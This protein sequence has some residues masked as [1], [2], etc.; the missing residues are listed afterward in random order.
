[1]SD[2]FDV[3]EDDPIFGPSSPAAPEST[4]VIDSPRQADPPGVLVFDVE[5]GPLSNDELDALMPAYDEAALGQSPGEF[6]PASVKYGN[7]KDEA[8]KAEKLAAAKAAHEQAVSTWRA[9]KNREEFEAKLRFREMAALSPVTGKVLAIEYVINGEHV[10][11]GEHVDEATLIDGWLDAVCEAHLTGNKIVGFNILGFDIPFLIRR[12]WKL[13][14]HV[15]TFLNPAQPWKCGVFIDLLDVWKCGSRF[16][17]PKHVDDKLA[18]V[19][20]FFGL[21]GKLDGLNGGDFHRLWN[22]SPEEREKALAYLTRDVEITY[23]VAKAMG[24]VR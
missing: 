8:K 5:T 1:M 2:P 22:G 7:T 19:A 23:G 14:L 15:P 13:G 24:I 12:A 3:F 4:A 18:T 9:K 16:S 21:E 6:D 11:Y 17:A 20:K 10:A